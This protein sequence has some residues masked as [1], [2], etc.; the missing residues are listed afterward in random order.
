VIY[1]PATGQSERY[2]RITPAYE[3][4]A[5]K[6]ACLNRIVA[7]GVSYMVLQRVSYRIFQIL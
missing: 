7:V 6:Y 4:A 5:E 3:T 2:W 1:T